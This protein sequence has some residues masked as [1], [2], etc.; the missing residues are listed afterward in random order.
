MLFQTWKPFY[1]QP[2]VAISRNK[3]RDFVFQRDG[4]LEDLGETDIAFSPNLVAGNKLAFNPNNRFEVALFSKYVSDQ[5][6]ANIDAENSKLDAYFTNDLVA[7]YQ[8]PLNKTFKSIELSAM[9]NNIFNG[10]TYPMDIT[11]LMMIPGRNQDKLSLWM[12]QILSTSNH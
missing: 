9:V 12:V 3:N 4:A 11:S 1:I 5:Y 10:N 8:I 6:M 2:N 7:N